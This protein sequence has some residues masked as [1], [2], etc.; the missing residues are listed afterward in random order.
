MDDFD[1]VLKC[2]GPVE[3][4]YNGYGNLVLTR[5]FIAHP[6][7]QKL[8]PKFADIPQGDLPGDGAVS[9]MGAGV[10][11]NLGEMLR[12]K[13][14]HAAIIKRLANI[15]AVQHKVPVCNFKLVGGVLGKLLG[16]KV[17]LDAD[18]QEALTRVMAVVVADMEVE[19]KNLGVTG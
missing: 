5:L 16:E 10:L 17:G 18:G 19:Y 13:G 9:A 14:K 7:T 2:W 11:K 12:L 3:A 15:H 8:F 1:M 6:H 4:D